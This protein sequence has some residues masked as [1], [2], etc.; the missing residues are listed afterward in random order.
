MASI[1]RRG[2]SW[3][4]RVTRAGFQPVVKTFT[5][6]LQ[7]EQWG[8][9]QEHALDLQACKGGIPAKGLTFGDLLQRYLECVTPTK[10][11]ADSEAWR[12]KA[13]LK[14]PIC[15]RP[16]SDINAADVTRYRD[17]R[18]KEV[19]SGTIHREFRLLMHVWSIAKREWLLM[20]S[21]NPFVEIRLPQLP[22][23]RQRRLSSDEWTALLAGTRSTRTR[24]LAPMMVLAYESAMRRSEILQLKRADVDLEKK[25][26]VIRHSKSGHSRVLPLTDQA[27]QAVE[28]WMSQSETDKVFDVSANA[29]RLAFERLCKKTGIQNFHWHDFRHCATSNFAEM[30]L[31]PVELMALTGHR[32]LGSLMRYAHVQ[33]KHLQEKIRNNCL[34]NENAVIYNLSTRSNRAQQTVQ[35]VAGT[36]PT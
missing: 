2:A 13:L 32:Q 11:G 17:Q 18:A 34:T 9:A 1:R 25:Y 6:K 24:W 28:Y 36:L 26:L 20:L 16:V 15:A 29:V 30:G 4:A 23:A 21:G 35:T 3:Q 10:R 31:S 8:R 14:R 7:A 12:I 19:S 33:G 5:S 22:P 27:A